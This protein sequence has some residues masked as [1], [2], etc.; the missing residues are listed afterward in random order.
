[1]PAREDKGQAKACPTNKELRACPFQVVHAARAAVPMRN[2]LVRRRELALLRAAGYRP[3]RS[4]AGGFLGFP[5]ALVAA[6]GIASFSIA[7]AVALRFPLLDAQK[8]E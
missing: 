7:T 8:A 6:N 3:R 1:V 2:V 4:C 5:P